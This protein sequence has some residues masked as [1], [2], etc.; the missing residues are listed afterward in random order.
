VRVRPGVGQELVIINTRRAV[1][2]AVIAISAA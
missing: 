1:W 2:G